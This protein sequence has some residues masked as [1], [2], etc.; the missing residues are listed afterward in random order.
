MT[1]RR[2]T[3][4]VGSSLSRPGPT[5][6]SGDRAFVPF[7]LDMPQLFET[8][9][10]E[11]LRVNAPPG[12]IVRRQHHAELDANFKIKIHVDIVIC[13]KHSGQPIAMLDTKYKA[14]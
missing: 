9:V 11:W 4:Y 7:E 2:C 6:S 14:D 1:T 12:T 5:F 13:E 3:G 8:F 10:A